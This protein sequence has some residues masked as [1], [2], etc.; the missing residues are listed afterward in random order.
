MSTIIDP[1]FFPL[2]DEQATA[3]K[4]GKPA[5]AS[6]MQGAI[7]TL[8]RINYSGRTLFSWWGGQQTTSGSNNCLRTV[9]NHHHQAANSNLGGESQH[10]FR[11]DVLATQYTA[12]AVA[13]QGLS[14]EIDGTNSTFP[15]APGSA[16]SS[17]VEP[18]HLDVYKLAAHVHENYVTAFGKFDLSFGAYTSN[19]PRM[20]AGCAYEPARNVV[21]ALTAS[22]SA[23][24]PQDFVAPD[25]GIVATG[26]GASLAHNNRYR[27]ML[28]HAWN[29]KRPTW[30]WSLVKPD[31][32]YVAFDDYTT[33]QYRYIFDQTIGDTGTA[34]SVTGPGIT[35]P[36]R[37]AA[38]GLNTTIK[39]A[40]YVYAKMS[41]ATDTGS[42]A[43]SHKAAGGASMTAFSTG[44]N[45]A[46]ISGTTAQWYPSLSGTPNTHDLRADLAFDRVVLAA[47]SNGATDHVRI[48]AIAIFPLH[49]STIT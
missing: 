24:V 37:Y 10:D 6:Q 18:T 23:W 41:G 35:I 3:G 16:P 21:P 9:Y 42:M 4:N 32:F 8:N 45:P 34:P 46:T 19:A 44:T 47:K 12:T 30:G 40:V 28:L 29:R 36:L 22:T 25:N 33:T 14:L 39:C 1:H 38:S 31:S 20:V 5:V 49:S 26:I 13:G 27:L 15:T 48:S 2:D 43:I 11:W 7:T 17:R